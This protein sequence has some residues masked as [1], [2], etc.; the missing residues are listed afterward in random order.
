MIAPIRYP[1]DDTSTAL[2]EARRAV[3]M[4]LPSRDA[5]DCE[6]PAIPAWQAWLLVAW[7]AVT[8][9]VFLSIMFAGWRG[10]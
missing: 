3:A 4:L 5:D 2:R 1:E 8:A 7:M 6:A 9:S 10:R